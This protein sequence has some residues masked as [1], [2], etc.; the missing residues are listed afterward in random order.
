MI[1]GG[2]DGAPVVGSPAIMVTGIGAL[3]Y[4]SASDENLRGEGRTPFTARLNFDRERIAHD[5]PYPLILWLE[6]ESLNVL[7]KQ[8]PDLSQWISAHFDFGGGA[9][10]DFAFERLFQS[11]EATWS[12]P[13]E[14]THADLAD[15]EGL[16]K[17]LDETQGS[18][19][20]HSLRKR[21][22]V[23]HALAVRY[24]GVG[25]DARAQT[26]LEQMLQLAIRLG[27]HRAEMIA[28]GNLGLIYRAT[29]HAERAIEYS[30]KALKIAREIGERRGEGAALGNL[31]ITY[32]EL[33]ET[34]R[35]VELYKQALRIARETGDPAAE[36]ETLGNLGVAYK[37]LGDLRRAVELYQQ[38]LEIARK[39]G[40]R[41]REGAA[42]GNL[43]IAYSLLGDV[44]R[45]IESHHQ[46][47]A[48]T[49]EVGDRRGEGNAL[50]NL[51]VEYARLGQARLAGE[52]FNQHLAIA[53]EIGDRRGEASALW[54]MSLA[55]HEL[56]DR[57]QAMAG[58]EAALKALEQIEDPAAATVRSQVEEWRRAD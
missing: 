18:D 43:G 20:V 24:Y 45:A 39:T 46:Q 28:L 34:Q 23:L 55:L 35:A 32:A 50:G 49:R 53:R 52:L 33:G 6:S 40:D 11:S 25:D 42:L 57:A 38:Q 19:D 13:K 8:A 15:F 58:A 36:G 48:I 2:L 21:L 31:G 3:I 54:N 1:R 17:E 12:Q 16:L 56:G 27:D 4:Q 10:K 9:V 51:G 30:E 47:L 7:L 29:G 44:H 26:H 41:R 5:L 22:A 37:S 14:Q